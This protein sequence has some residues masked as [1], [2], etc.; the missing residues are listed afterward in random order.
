MPTSPFNP[1][2]QCLEQERRRP[3]SSELSFIQNPEYIQLEQYAKRETRNDLTIEE[4]GKK[5]VLPYIVDP[6]QGFGQNPE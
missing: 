6:F 3:T 2:T 4:V 5:T 1:N